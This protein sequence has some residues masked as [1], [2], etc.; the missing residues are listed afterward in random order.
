MAES[1]AG[2][3][4]QRTLPGLDRLNRPYWTGGGK[5]QLLI[6]QCRQCAY[7]LHPPMPNCRRCGSDRIEP[8]PVSGRGRVAS[9]TV[10]HQAW[11]PG[12]VVPFVFAAVELSEQPEL[13]VFTNIVGCET[14]DVRADMAVKVVF[15]RNE[16]VFL[17]MFVPDVAA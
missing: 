5:D 7:Y 13:Y 17:P 10:N 16:D 3:P 12:M 2:S 15:E 14:G 11:L 4:P 8:T 1:A 6:A 9:F